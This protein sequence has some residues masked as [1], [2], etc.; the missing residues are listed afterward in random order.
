MGGEC[1]EK[2]ATSVSYRLETDVD[3]K[4]DPDALN[5]VSVQLPVPGRPTA[6]FIR[7]T[8]WEPTS[9]APSAQIDPVVP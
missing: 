6:R 1:P 7:V 4:N 5:C 9:A 3:L 8:N 2:Y